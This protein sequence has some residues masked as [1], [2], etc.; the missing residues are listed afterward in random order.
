MLKDPH[1]VRFILS[2]ITGDNILLFFC[3]S[4]FFASHCISPHQSRL[5]LV[6][7]LNTFRKRLASRGLGSLVGIADKFG[8]VLIQLALRQRFAIQNN[9]WR[10]LVRGLEALSGQGDRMHER[11]SL[12]SLHAGS[13]VALIITPPN[14]GSASRSGTSWVSAAALNAVH[15]REPV[16]GC[17]VIFNRA[18]LNHISKT[19][20]SS[21]LASE[22]PIPR[23]AFGL[24]SVTVGKETQIHNR[25]DILYGCTHL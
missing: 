4:L 11:V 7:L 6:C 14:F 25:G 13:D 22:H 19:L 17:W 9:P 21:M 2:E 12:R 5:L 20:S 3:S 10:P 1:Y 16:S 15:K 8:E 24:T 23:G 18:G